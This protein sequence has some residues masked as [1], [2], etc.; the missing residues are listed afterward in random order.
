MA[1]IFLDSC[2]VI[3]LREGTHDQRSRIAALLAAAVQEGSTLNVSE[4]VRFECRVGPL[5]RGDAGLLADYESFFSLPG[6]ALVPL[7]RMV[8][9]RAAQLRATT[10]VRTPDALH[11]AAALASG[12]T[13]LWTNDRRLAVLEPAIRVVVVS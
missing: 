4:L 13:E 3:Y 8:F 12:C 9:D 5:K 6:L 1:G 7:D 10:G 2:I 11:G